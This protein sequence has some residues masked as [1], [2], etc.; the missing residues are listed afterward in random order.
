MAMG[1]ASSVSMDCL[2]AERFIRK[3]GCASSSW[4]VLMAFL[5]FERLI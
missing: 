1:N 2:L 3:A 4:D 5:L